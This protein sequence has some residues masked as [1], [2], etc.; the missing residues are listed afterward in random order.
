MLMVVL[1]MHLE[2]MVDEQEVELMV[3]ENVKRMLVVEEVDLMLEYYW[4]FVE[5]IMENHLMELHL[6]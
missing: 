3:M 2:P 5:I 4:I 1:E 6:Y